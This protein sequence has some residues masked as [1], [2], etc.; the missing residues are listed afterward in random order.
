MP[1]TSIPKPYP[2]ALPLDLILA[3]AELLQIPQQTTSTALVYY[4]TWTTWEAEAST[5][6]LFHMDE[7][8]LA[9]ASIHLACKQTE[10]PRKLR[11]VLN[12]CYWLI[13]KSSAPTS[14]FLDT[15]EQIYWDLKD[16]LVTAEMMLLR[17]LDFETGVET[18]Y[19][20]IPLLVERWRQ[21]SSNMGMEEV[22]K[23]AEVAWM[24]MNAA[25]LS[26]RTCLRV[27][28]KLMAHVSVYLSVKLQFG[29]VNFETFCDEMKTVC[30]VDINAGI[31]YM[32]VL[33]EV[34]KEG[35]MLQY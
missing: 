34:L 1:P 28:S 9:T 6:E 3:S 14:A 24:F 31:R 17:V 18:G 7:I 21:H 10:S 15:D 5:T 19:V 16:S 26:A 23:V 32:N 33:V 8:L 29:E 30:S 2:A 35:D 27:D 12:V 22:R 20:Y 25:Y 4:H 13:H 11:D